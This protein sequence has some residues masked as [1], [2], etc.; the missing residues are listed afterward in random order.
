MALVIARTLVALASLLVVGEII[1]TATGV[2]LLN[3]R[4]DTQPQPCL[5]CDDGT[6]G[7][8]AS[9]TLAP[10]IT[11]G[12]G[13][14]ATVRQSPQLQFSLPS[15]ET[16]T[17]GARGD[18]GD[19]LVDMNDNVTVL[20]TLLANLTLVVASNY[21]DVSP[22]GDA[23]FAPTFVAGVVTP[24]PPGAEALASNGGTPTAAIL[25]LALPQGEAGAAPILL[26]GN[27]EAGDE[28]SVVNT[29]NATFVVL[30]VT[31]ARGFAGHAATVAAGNTTVVDTSASVVNAGTPEAVILDY[32]M[33]RGAKGAPGTN[34][35]LT[36]EILTNGTINVTE[37]VVDATNITIVLNENATFAT[38][39][40]PTGT[41]GTTA[42]VTVEA[43]NGPEGSVPTVTNV[44][45]P[46]AA[47]FNFVVPVGAT[48]AGT[49]VTLGNVTTL[50]AGANGSVVN[51]GTASAVVL[52]FALAPGPP[53]PTAT[54]AIG[55]VSALPVGANATVT[56]VGTPSAAV[57][58]IGVPAGAQGVA[59]LGSISVGTV[60]TL[61]PGAEATVA[62]VGSAGA[63]ILNFGLPPGY[64][65]TNGTSTTLAVGNV[66]TAT[67]G[68]AASVT[69][70]G[71]SSALVLNFVLPLEDSASGVLFNANAS[72]VQALVANS[73]QQVAFLNSSTFTASLPLTST[74][75]FSPSANTVQYNGTATVAAVAMLSFSL[76][77][78][79]GAAFQFGI[80]T[81]GATPVTLATCGPATVAAN[82]MINLACHAFA[83]SVTPGTT[84]AAWL[85]PDTAGTATTSYTTLTVFY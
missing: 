29:G 43:T 85:N 2:T 51:A 82:T 4:L 64:G 14:N 16:G 61:A 39:P 73:W 55:N 67:W 69:N 63:A 41:N 19:V 50:A 1:A 81:N 71:T 32:A 77:Y 12:A 70:V 21:S 17:G 66:T 83:P 10:T 26:V 78:S 57:F 31:T 5:A 30:D 35:N 18:N 34:A 46:N 42:T 28:A 54:G 68:A 8:N 37:F 56:N 13:A 15:G 9:V 11:L 45:T 36:L 59:G 75:F 7:A 58:N 6:D 3:Q 27:T 74:N 80:G 24:L 20:E 52:D 62:N 76:A 60:T 49:N 53:G 25:N 84:F 33:R 65:V 23:G 40:G 38:L 72:D 22:A 47:I 44:G 79:T 48:G